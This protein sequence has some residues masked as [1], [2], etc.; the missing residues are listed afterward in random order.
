V[1]LA[2]MILATALLFVAETTVVGHEAAGRLV[3]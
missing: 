1:L 2:Y 3:V